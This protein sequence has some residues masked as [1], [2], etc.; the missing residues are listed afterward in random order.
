MIHIYAFDVVQVIK[1][2]DI[3]RGLKL[4]PVYQVSLIANA[5]PAR[6]LCYLLV[7]L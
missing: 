7:L 3:K 2:P 1:N 5:L 4:D 6:M